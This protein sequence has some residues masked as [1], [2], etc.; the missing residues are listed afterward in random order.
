MSTRISCD[1]KYEY[2]VVVREGGIEIFPVVR[3]VAK[4]FSLTDTEAKGPSNTAMVI[5]RPGMKSGRRAVLTSHP[6][7]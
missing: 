6:D 1:R 5:R 4:G 3:G 7:P 2:A